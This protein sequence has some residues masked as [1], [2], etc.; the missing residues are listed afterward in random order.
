MSRVQ[1]ILCLIVFLGIGNVSKL[2]AQSISVWTTQS[3]E[4]KKPYRDFHIIGFNKSE[5]DDEYLSDWF[6]KE[7]KENFNNVKNIYSYEPDSNDRFVYEEWIAPT[8]FK[9]TD[10]ILT[11]SLLPVEKKKSKK[12][13]YNPVLEEPYNMSLRGY[14][15]QK[16][17][18]PLEVEN[19]ND[20]WMVE[21]KIYH[22]ITFNMMFSAKSKTFSASDPKRK[23]QKY[24]EKMIQKAIRN[25]I[26][27]EDTP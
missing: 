11:Y 18:L 1:H 26:I 17:K 2:S 7:I 20:L 19:Y 12:N 21:I 9:G 10:V 27:N 14:I 13:S 8:K 6:Y 24:F 15:L 16:N 5:L 3:T 23:A 22:P 4:R 25:D